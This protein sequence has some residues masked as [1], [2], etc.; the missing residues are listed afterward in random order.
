MRSMALL[1]ALAGAAIAA[2][3]W[4][5]ACSSDGVTPNCPASGEGCVTPPGDA[6]PSDD[7]GTN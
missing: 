2:A 3:C 1:V 4:A 5:V 6:A 7:G